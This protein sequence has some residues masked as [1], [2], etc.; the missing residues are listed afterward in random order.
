MMIPHCEECGCTA[1]VDATVRDHGVCQTCRDGE[2]PPCL[3][4]ARGRASE[5]HYPY[6]SQACGD[7]ADRENDLDGVA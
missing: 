2:T 5:T 4:C 7:A 6:C 1:D 3:W